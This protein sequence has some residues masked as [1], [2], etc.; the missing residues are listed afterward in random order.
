MYQLC[1]WRRRWTS[2]D[3]RN[4]VPVYLDRITLVDYVIIMCLVYKPSVPEFWVISFDWWAHRRYPYIDWYRNTRAATNAHAPLMQK[5]FLRS[6]PRAE[7][8]RLR[9][10]VYVW[11]SLTRKVMAIF[12][13]MWTL[14][15]LASV[16]AL[17]GAQS[18]SS[19]GR[20]LTDNFL[21]TC[22]YSSTHTAPIGAIVGIVFGIFGAL[23]GICVPIGI[24]IFIF[25]CVAAQSRRHHQ[26]PIY[27]TRKTTLVH[28]HIHGHRF[29]YMYEV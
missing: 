23:L 6:P 3:F 28:T 21:L 25:C 14:L 8:I 24:W 9:C 10:H 19:S 17:A 2:Q 18:D 26:Q 7:N 20:R 11:R 29:V 16:I 5:T 13:K 27:I 22:W 15:C 12:D 4:F 1:A